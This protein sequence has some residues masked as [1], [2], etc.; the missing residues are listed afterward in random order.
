[1]A[2]PE[3][4]FS[5]SRRGHAAD[6]IYESLAAAILRGQLAPG[7]SLPPE[8]VLAEQF[9]VS[10]IIVRQAVHRLAEC[11]LL[12]VR[13]GGATTV[14]DPQQAADLRVLELDY[15]LGPGSPRDVYDFTERQIMQGF[16]I[17]YLAERR[18][19][20]AQF[21]ELSA[22]V[23]DYA[24][25][26]FDDAGIA[27]FE[28]RFWKKLSAIAGNRLYL[29]EANWWYRVIARQPRT[30]HPVLAPPEARNAF[31]REL[32][33]RLAA[34]DG[35]AQFY[36]EMSARVLDALAPHRE[37]NREPQGATHDAPPTA[38]TDKPRARRRL[39]R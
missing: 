6:D 11:G 8:R 4:V 30:Q 31:F 7:T 16:S 26:G 15:R 12:R 37:L 14:L 28:E 27:E 10:R 2:L 17:M 5:P 33:R 35:G 20:P 9:G 13:Q 23:E 34:K 24:A 3:P 32:V 19:T 1:M 21:A 39:R 25:R 29:F 38:V 18:G 22:I 36:L